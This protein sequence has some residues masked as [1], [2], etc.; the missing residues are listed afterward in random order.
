MKTFKRAHT[1]IILLL[2]VLAACTVGAA[3]PKTWVTLTNCQYVPGEFNDGDSFRVRSGTNEYIFRLYF[4]DAPETNLRYA[5][6][7][8]EQSE[9]FGVTLD[10]TMKAGVKAKE[11]VQEFLKT[12]FVV[13][14]R[15]STGG[16]RSKEPRYYSLVEVGGTNLA[17]FLVGQGLARNKGA[18]A[19][20]PS[21][22]KSKVYIEKLQALEDEAKRKGLGVWAGLKEKNSV[23]K[24]ESEAQ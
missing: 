7:T 5:E 24:T 19:N 23:K 4:V 9:Y 10:E 16:G 17:E 8:R 20:P 15:W 3:E 21:G 6:R 13:R 1:K 12:P 14:T 11:V 18:V 2:L 22:M